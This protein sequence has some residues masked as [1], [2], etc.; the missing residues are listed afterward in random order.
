MI[1]ASLKAKCHGTFASVIL[2]AHSWQGC[3][4]QASQIVEAPNVLCMVTTR[5]LLLL[6]QF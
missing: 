3:Y 1:Q 4:N 2:T 6:L 5:M